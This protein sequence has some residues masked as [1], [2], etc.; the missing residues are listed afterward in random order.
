MHK[1]SFNLKSIFS[2]SSFQL[3]IFISGLVINKCIAIYS[4]PAGIALFGVIKNFHVFFGS[5]LKLGSDNVIIN[6]ASKA[7]KS[8][9]QKKEL[10]SSILKLCIFQIMFVFFTFIIMDGLIYDLVFQSIIP[11]EEKWLV[12]LIL[13]LIFL[14]V[15][16]EMIVSFFNGLLDLKKVFISGFSGSFLTMLL[17][18][19]IQPTSFFEISI[20]ALSSGSFS[21]IILLYFL[22]QNSYIFSLDE[23]R[24][25][26]TPETTLPISLPLL[27]QPILVSTA[28]LVIQN[29]ISSSYGMK[30]LSF[31]VLCTT[32]VG[33]IMSLMMASGRMYF[34]P[35]LGSLIDLDER[36][37][38][39]Q[40]NIYFFLIAASIVS[41][42]IFFFAP[43]I[44]QI[45]Y[46]DKF[47]EASLLL[48]LLSS[49]VIL[50]SFEWIIAISS[51][52]K[53]RYKIYI[54]PEFIREVLYVASCFICIWLQLEFVY[55]FIGFLFS[56]I[57]AST[58]WIGY[59]Y[60]YK[61]ELSIHPFTIATVYI[62]TFLLIVLNYH[63]I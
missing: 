62:I 56:E 36:N 30:E 25:H 9:A 18:L 27:I 26:K 4:G 16:S 29:L 55:I 53:S 28:F 21:A 31:F 54:I 1:S 40:T 44:I 41:F 14:T 46:S 12:R 34:L 7:S 11:S 51:W 17:A 32:L 48:S 20:L 37:R 63:A 52:E 6:R 59:L 50:K 39:F 23:D 24:L 43:L 33:V 19:S 49:T 8:N 3:L 58:F 13:I 47:L 22:F 61:S 10:I 45:L 15:F 2:T 38:F 57:I 60:F 5:I 35:K 42:I